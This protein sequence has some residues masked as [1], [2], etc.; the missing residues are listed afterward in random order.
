MNST[1]PY[2]LPGTALKEQEGGD[3]T[4]VAAPDQD[5]GHRVGN[6][7]GDGPEDGPAA[8]TT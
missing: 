1:V 7:D 3:E 6:R 4:S 2:Q 5:V 8:K